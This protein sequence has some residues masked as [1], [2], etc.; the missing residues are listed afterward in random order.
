MIEVFS[1]GG[2]TQSCCISAMIVLGKLPKPD[3]AVIVDTERER[4][5]VWDYH[6]AYV[7][8]SLASVGVTIHRVAKSRYAT[9]D[10]WGGKRGDSLLIP[11]F[12]NQAGMPPGKLTGFCSNEWKVRVMARFLS[13]EHGVPVSWQRRWIGFSAD[14]ARRAVRM[15]GTI[16]YKSGKIRFPLINDRPMRRDD[17]IK[18]VTR[19]MGWPEPPRSACWMCPN[20]HDDEWESLT[21]EEFSAACAID[22][23]M[24]EKDPFAYLHSSCIPLDQVDFSALRVAREAKK[25]ADQDSDLF[26]RA[27]NSGSCFL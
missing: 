26:S 20:Q 7:E 3:F 19:E 2:G 14:E 8:P 25:N 27:C 15:M 11:A 21:P 16:D 12:S 18:F 22:R 17:S 1:S 4:Q 5:S 10:L 6:H 24:R 13:R 23:E 9:V